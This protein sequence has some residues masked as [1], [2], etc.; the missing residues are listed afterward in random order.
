MVKHLPAV[1]ETQVQSLGW[2]DPLEKGMATHSSILTW[3]I[4]WTEE[5][6]GLQ[7]IGL[8][9]VR[10]DWVNDTFHFLINWMWQKWWGITSKI[11]L[12]KTVASILEA[13]VF[14]YSFLILEKA[15]FHDMKQLYSKIPMNEIGSRF[16]MFCQKFCV[17]IQKQCLIQLNLQR[18]QCHLTVWLLLCKRWT[19]SKNPVFIPLW[20]SSSS[21]YYSSH[22]YWQA[23]SCK[24]LTHTLIFASGFTCIYYPV[25][26]LPHSFPCLLLF[27]HST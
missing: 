5:P 27:S 21:T 9:R 25:F 17:W 10:R 3:R 12:S 18:Q 7:S 4:S 15:S 20:G 26:L 2:G 11:R 13:L 19:L 24:K 14:S 23:Y 8:Q 22:H 6:G 1:Q 16:S